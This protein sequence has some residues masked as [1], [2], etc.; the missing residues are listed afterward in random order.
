VSRKY[1][2]PPTALKQVAQDFGH[3]WGQTALE[4][5]LPVAS[6]DL[7]NRGGR[8][9]LAGAIESRHALQT[10]YDYV[11]RRTRT[12]NVYRRLLVKTPSP[13]TAGKRELTVR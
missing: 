5:F 8:D 4:D 9:W 11:T 6:Q 1:G 13:N 12:R 7:G 3:C 2:Q 10:R